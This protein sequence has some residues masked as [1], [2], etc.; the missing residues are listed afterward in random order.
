MEWQL[1]ACCTNSDSSSHCS[2]VMAETAPDIYQ[3][4]IWGPFSHGKIIDDRKAFSN[5]EKFG[6]LTLACVGPTSGTLDSPRIC[7]K[8]SQRL[9]GNHRTENARGCRVTSQL[10]FHTHAS[11]VLRYQFTTEGMC[12]FPSPIF[13]RA[14]LIPMKLLKSDMQRR[15]LSVWVT[16]LILSRVAVLVTSLFTSTRGKILYAGVNEVWHIWFEVQLLTICMFSLGESLV[17]F[18]QTIL[19]LAFLGVSTL[20]THS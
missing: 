9:L 13:F 12:L 2:W 7:D 11:A 14:D 19:D 20:I 10:A 6:G 3:P 4:S 5:K 8:L 1:I 16:M 15:N 18:L 17:S